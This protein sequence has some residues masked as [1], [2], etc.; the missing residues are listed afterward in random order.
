MS[1]DE[2]KRALTQLPDEWWLTYL[3]D[4][5]VAVIFQD[6]NVEIERVEAIWAGEDNLFEIQQ[7]P[8]RVNG[9]SLD[10]VIE[11]R[12]EEGDITPIFDRVNEKSQFGTIRVNVKNLSGKA[13]RSLVEYLGRS[14]SDHRTDG[15]VMVIA[16]YDYDPIAKLDYRGLDWEFA[17]EKPDVLPDY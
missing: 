3:P 7:V 16:Y 12:W 15:G 13:R 6:K 10:D 4:E 11:V 17:D 8:L 2:P 5:S 9:V 14:I 1:L